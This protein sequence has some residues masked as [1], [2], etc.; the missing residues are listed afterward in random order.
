[1]IDPIKIHFRRENET[2]NAVIDFISDEGSR[3]IV[4]AIAPSLG[5]LDRAYA[6][7]RAQALADL[8]LEIEQRIQANEAINN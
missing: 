6:A 5:E 7:G 4:D 1:M 3:E 2:M 8:L